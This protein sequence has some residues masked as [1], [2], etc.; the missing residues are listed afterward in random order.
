MTISVTHVTASDRYAGVEAHI[1]TLATAQARA[2]LEVSVVG[3]APERMQ[4]ELT[5]YGVGFTPARTVWDAVL[6]VRRSGTQVIH[7]HLTAA[8]LAAYLGTRLSRTPVVATRHTPQSRGATRLRRE[9]LRHTVSRAIA[10]ETA[11]SGYAAAFI[12]GPCTVIHAGVSTERLVPAPDR[13]PVILIAQRMEPEKATSEGVEIA[14][15]SGLLDEGWRL[16]IAGDGAL[17]P[18]IEQQLAALGIADRTSLLG[19]VADARVL[20]RSA[21]VLL[22]PCPAEAYGLS[23]VEAMACGLPVVASGAGGHVE[24]VGS[25]TPES[26]FAPG[27]IASGAR[28]LAELAADPSRRDRVGS[29]LHEAQQRS[30]TLERQVELTSQVYRSVL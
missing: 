5:S 16:H 18:R 21:G 24:T 14:A 11:V 8:D 26:L 25:V 19:R 12:E 3:G 28:I 27:D 22:A 4:T 10:A 13:A 15:A 2:G 30:F 7:S 23:V 17:R 9:A 1:R 6:A 20:M 29:S